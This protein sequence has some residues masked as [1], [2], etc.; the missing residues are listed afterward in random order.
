M[1][2][3]NELLGD[4]NLLK[5]MR[6]D[7]GAIDSADVLFFKKNCSSLSPPYHHDHKDTSQTNNIDD[8]QFF[9]T[10]SK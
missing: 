7:S 8:I 4:I 9:V 5:S 3:G 2:M 10:E 1:S 6:D